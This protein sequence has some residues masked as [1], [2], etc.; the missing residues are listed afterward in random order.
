[1]KPLK[2]LP[3]IIER[4]GGLENFTHV[5]L[6]AEGF[7]PLSI[8]RLEHERG[9]NGGA[10]V[11]VMHTYLQNGDVMRDPEVVFE[12]KDDVWSPIS[13]RQDSLGIMQEAVYVEEGKT[14]VRPKLL[15][16]ITK[17]CMQ[18]DRNLKDQGFLTAEPQ[19]L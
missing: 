10:L 2:T 9:P 1:M 15:A 7:M 12:V 8:Q 6:H 5:Q 11:S 14:M 19:S 16:D 3:A 18:W 13:Y 4:H 17:F